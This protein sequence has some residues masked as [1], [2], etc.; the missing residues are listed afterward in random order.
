MLYSL[1]RLI[2]SV[3]SWYERQCAGVSAPWQEGA[4]RRL[5]TSPKCLQCR[6]EIIGVTFTLRSL[7]PPIHWLQRCW[8]E[9]IA[10]NRVFE[11]TNR[12]FLWICV[13]YMGIKIFWQIISYW[14]EIVSYVSK[15]LSESSFRILTVLGLPWRWMHYEWVN[16]IWV[17]ALPGTMHLGLKTSPL[18]PV[19]YY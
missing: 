10:Q 5:R 11:E 8:G 18:C 19:I 7:Y 2:L 1:H 13:F 12:I 14:M 6:Y 3:D 17:S 16:G 4:Y 9:V 15:K